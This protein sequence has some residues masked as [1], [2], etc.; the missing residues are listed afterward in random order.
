M[1]T[2]GIIGIVIGGLVWSAI[3]FHVGAFVGWTARS[4]AEFKE[5]K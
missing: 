4:N 1:S 3:V 2:L 5:R